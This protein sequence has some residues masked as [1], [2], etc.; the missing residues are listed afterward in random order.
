MLSIINALVPVFLIIVLG[1]GLK[2]TSLFDEATWT[3]FENLCYFVLFPALLIKTL[4]TAELGSTEILRFSL[5]L[6]FAIF[7]MSALMLIF[8]PLMKRFL[9]VSPMSF[10]SLLQGATR[11]HGFI[12]LSLEQDAVGNRDGP[13]GMPPVIAAPGEPLTST[14]YQNTVIPYQ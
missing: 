2:R 4:A 6:L 5:M 13:G 3:G 8:F 10:T 9:D 12:A 11:F 14:I 1:A 7:T